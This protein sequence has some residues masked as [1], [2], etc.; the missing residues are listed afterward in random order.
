MK[1]PEAKNLVTLKEN[2]SLLA[3]YSHH[4]GKKYKS[5]LEFSNNLWGL[6]TE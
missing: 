5:V 2:L 1:K 3:Y 6:G 4:A